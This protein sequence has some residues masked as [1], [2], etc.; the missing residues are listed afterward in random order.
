MTQRPIYGVDIR[1]WIAVV[2]VL[3]GTALVLWFS[4]DYDFTRRFT[5]VGVTTAVLAIVLVWA[6]LRQHTDD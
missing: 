3:V 4:V 5:L 1:V 2:M 6:I